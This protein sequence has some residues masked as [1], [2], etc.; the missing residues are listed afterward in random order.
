[1]SDDRPAG[2][3]QERWDNLTCCACYACP[4]HEHTCHRD[5]QGRAEAVRSYTEAMREALQGIWDV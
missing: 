5:E 2:Y 4:D 3:T 1:M